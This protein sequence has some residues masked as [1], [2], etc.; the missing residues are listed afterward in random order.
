ML[1]SVALS[2]IQRKKLPIGSFSSIV[3]LKIFFFSFFY[4]Q[5]IGASTY[6]LGRS[7][8]ALRDL[9]AGEE[10]VSAMTDAICRLFLSW[11]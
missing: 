8:Y 7:F 10:I 9:Q 4:D 11:T 5:G 2:T 6:N 1:F 3:E